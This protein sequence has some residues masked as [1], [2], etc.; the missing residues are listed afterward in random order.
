MS[1]RRGSAIALKASDVVAA[2]V[3]TQSYSRTGICQAVRFLKFFAAQ[4]Q[5][6][7]SVQFRLPTTQGLPNDD[8]V[9]PVSSLRSA[10]GA[11]GSP[12]S[13]RNTLRV[14][15]VFDGVRQTETRQFR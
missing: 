11:A 4:R 2:R 6:H 3:I 15:F 8:F 12:S 7:G 13:D 1:R 14:Q 9:V 5:K 10:R